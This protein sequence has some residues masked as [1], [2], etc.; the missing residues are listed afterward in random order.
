MSDNINNNQDEISAGDVLSEDEVKGRKG[1]HHHSH[2]HRHHSRGHHSHSG[3]KYHSHR[4]SKCREKSKK[5]SERSSSEMERAG[6][7]IIYERAKEYKMN[8]FMKRSLFC[9]VAL[10]FIFFVSASIIDPDFM[11][12]FMDFGRM[13]KKEKERNELKIKIIQYEERIEEL[14]EIIEKY[15]NGELP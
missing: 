8:M 15:E 10:L 9:I 13:N 4:E 6:H 2:S 7:S 11:T 12:D 5:Y 1:H 3:K 14:E